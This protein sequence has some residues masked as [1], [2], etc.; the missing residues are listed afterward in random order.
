[1]EDED[2][3][4]EED[5]ELVQVSH[6]VPKRLRED[7]S[8]NTEFGGVSH[9]VREVYRILANNGTINE[10]RLQIQ[11]QTV[12]NDRERIEGEIADLSDQLDEMKRRESELE[13][14]LSDIDS[15]ESKFEGLMGELETML[16]NGERVFPAHGK[17]KRAADMAGLTP[18]E[19]ISQLKEQNPDCPDEQFTEKTPEWHADGG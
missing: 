9:A 10:S 6:M 17:V 3:E 4:S 15:R 8:A 16:E 11:L 7:A 14:R 1:M 12:R 5:E 13:D 2:A 18:N 19:V